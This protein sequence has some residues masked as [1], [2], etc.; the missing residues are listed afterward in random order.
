MHIP[1]NSPA[2]YLHEENRAARMLLDLL[3]KE[4]AQLIAADI[5]GLTVSTEEKTRLVTEMSELAARRHQALAAEGFEAKE[6][7]MQAWLKNTKAPTAAQSWKE[8]LELA[9]EAKDLNRI[10]GML[11]GQHLARS[12]NALNVL[13]GGTQGQTFYGPNGQSSVNTTVRGLAIG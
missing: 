10:N 8:L 12:Q 3:K 6:E 1:G 9:Q 11:I 7:G 2:H 5:D 13:K 4:Q